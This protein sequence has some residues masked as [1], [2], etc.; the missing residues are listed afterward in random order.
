[1]SDMM[2]ACQDSV[3]LKQLDTRL[4]SFSGFFNLVFTIGWA[5][6]D[7]AN[8]NLYSSM[9]QLAGITSLSCSDI[10]Y[11]FGMM[12]SSALEAKSPSAVFYNAVSNGIS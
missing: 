4:S 8:S 7:K 12:W 2:V 10:G 5:F 1:M 9:M 6:I 11:N 3:K